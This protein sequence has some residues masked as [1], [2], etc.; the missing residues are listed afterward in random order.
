MLGLGAATKM[1]S[2]V[3]NNSKK[4]ADLSQTNMNE[5]ASAKQ[6]IKK[7]SHQADL[8]QLREDFAEKQRLKDMQSA[9]K[10]ITNMLMPAV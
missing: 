5:M 10:K 6:E 4:S 1:A 3:M 2:T 8:Q 9:Q 7:A